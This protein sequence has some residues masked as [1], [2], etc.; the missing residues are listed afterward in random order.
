MGFSDFKQKAVLI[1]QTGPSIGDYSPTPISSFS[2]NLFIHREVVAN[3]LEDDTLYSPPL[4]LTPTIIILFSLLAGLTTLF[5]VRI[6]ALLFPASLFMYL[7]LS[8]FLFLKGILLNV[9][10]PIL[11]GF[12]SYSAST[13]YALFFE[14][15][16]K[17]RIRF[18]FKRYV[19]E[20]VVDKILNRQFEALRRKELTI[21]FSDIK[22]FGEFSE[23][24]QPEEIT[25]MLRRY[26]DEMTEIVFKYGGT[27]DKFIG[28]GMLAFFGDP[29]ELPNHALSAVNSALEMQKKGSLLNKEWEREGRE[30]IEIKIGINTGFVTVGAIGS[31]RRSE[32]TVLGREVNLA[33]RLEAKATPGKILISHRTFS[34]VKDRIK[35]KE[36]GEIE[37]KGERE[38]VM[39]YE[40]DPSL[41]DL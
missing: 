38:P 34:L 26:F 31:K 18:F 15:K 6:N 27:L 24:A 2:P 8:F 37:V 5:P 28:D 16:E 22:G 41:I 21:L 10:S 32:Y 13:G 29:D 3:L 40:V 14:E 1:G 9:F 19:S 20:G 17:R 35:A 23:R 12:L 11:A 30:T 36:L 4:W 25:E 33:Q 39:V 7:F